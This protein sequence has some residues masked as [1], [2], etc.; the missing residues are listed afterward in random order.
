MIGHQTLCAIIYTIGLLPLFFIMMW[1]VPDIVKMMVI[2][3][4]IFTLFALV[5]ILYLVSVNQLQPAINKVDPEKKE[6]W[7]EFSESG[8]FTLKIAD[9]D[10]H[11]RSKGIQS[12]QKADIINRGKFTVRFRNGNTGIIVFDKM[13]KAVDPKEAIAWTKIFKKIK[14]RSGKEAYEKAKE[15]KQVGT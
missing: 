3:N 4:I 13:S 10:A 2:C 5:W 8:L 1:P 14:V 9:K 15:E 11:G 12:K 6:I 7:V